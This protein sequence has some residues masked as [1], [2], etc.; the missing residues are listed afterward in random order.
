MTQNQKYLV[1]GASTVVVGAIIYFSFFNN[2]ESGN[3]IDPTGNG[4]VG[5][6]GT[7]NTFNANKVATEL[8]EIMAPAGYA[9]VILNSEEAETILSILRKVSPAQFEQVVKSFGK[10]NYNKTLGSQYFL[11]FTT[12]EKHDLIVWLKTELGT[13]SDTYKTLKLKYPNIL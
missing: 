11:P 3:G 2:S 6:L 12:P 1:Y 4:S 13:S 5:D 7:I 8:W 9:N 10:L